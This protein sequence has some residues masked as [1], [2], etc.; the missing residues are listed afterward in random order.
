MSRGSLHYSYDHNRKKILVNSVCSLIFIKN[1]NS[2]INSELKSATPRTTLEIFSLFVLQHSTI[3]KTFNFPIFAFAHRSLTVCLPFAQ[4]A[5][6]IIHRLFLCS[7]IRSVCAHLLKSVHR[8]LKVVDAQ[9]R[10]HT[11]YNFFFHY[12]HHS[13]VQSE[14]NRIKIHEHNYLNTDRKF[15][16]YSLNVILMNKASG[17]RN[18]KH[19]KILI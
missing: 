11:V 5:F 3:P 17:A 15:I 7:S 14:K 8:S 18:I 19:V 16:K 13:N 6:N 10:S 4:R 2:E 1:Q 9:N 12:H